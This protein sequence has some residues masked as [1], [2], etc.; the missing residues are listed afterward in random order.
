MAT[1]QKSRTA[2][3]NARYGAPALKTGRKSKKERVARCTWPY[4]SE[5]VSPPEWL[6]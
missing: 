1:E 4:S 5:W 6:T 3:I 2:E